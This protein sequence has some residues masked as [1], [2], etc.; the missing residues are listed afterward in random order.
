MKFIQKDINK[1]LLYLLLIPLIL[2]ILVAVYYQYKFKNVS[3]EYDKDKEEL[4]VFTGR[5]VLEQLNKTISDQVTAQKG[6]ELLEQWYS[7]LKAENEE[8]KKQLEHLKNES[9]EFDFGANAQNIDLR[10][11]HNR[12]TMLQKTLTDVNVQ[13]A[14]I[15]VKIRELCE[16]TK[17]A[18]Q[19][20]E[21]C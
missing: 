5:I 4:E 20:N 3:V 19:K 16:E 13:I 6:K 1:T 10:K 18:G 21:K 15:A 8:L 7:N 17:S 12:I 11:L 2:S 9:S 14:E